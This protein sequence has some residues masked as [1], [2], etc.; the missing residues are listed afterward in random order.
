M[1]QSQ[2]FDK[3]YNFLKL[4]L[5]IFILRNLIVVWVEGVIKEGAI[6]LH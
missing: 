5:N 4:V 2:D 6:I 1:G 3:I